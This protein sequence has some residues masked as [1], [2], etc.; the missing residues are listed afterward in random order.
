MR[1]PDKY[2]LLLIL[3][4][5]SFALRLGYI[6]E[7]RG[8]PSFLRLGRGLDSYHF[9]E[10]AE[11]ISSG[12][13]LLKEKEFYQAPLYS[14]FLAAVYSAF[15]KNLQAARVCQ[16]FLSSLGVLLVFLLAFQYSQRKTAS[17]FSAIVWAFYGPS[18]FYDG[19][20]LKTSF[21]L[22]Q[23]FL[24]MIFIYP[25]IVKDT[26]GLL[27]GFFA[28]SLITTRP[29]FAVLVPFLTGLKLLYPAKKTSGWKQLAL[30]LAG[31]LVLPG[32][33][34]IRNATLGQ[35]WFKLSSVGPR[36]VIQGQIPDDTRIGWDDSSRGDRMLHETQ[37]DLKKVISLLQEEIRKEPMIWLRLQKQKLK[38]FFSWYEYP[39]NYNFYLAKKDSFSLKM[40]FI[41]FIPV[42]IFTLCAFFISGR[43]FQHKALFACIFMIVFLCVFPFYPF[44]RFRMPLAAVLSIPS[45]IF[46]LTFFQVL[47]KK[48]ITSSFL[49][50]FITAVSFF[51]PAYLSRHFHLVRE[52]DYFNYGNYY[53]ECRLTGESE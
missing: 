17:F 33:F 16:A 32:L 4:I 36:A 46:V 28:G 14:Y 21:I 43:N 10:E 18:L 50:V 47:K 9:H 40:S 27:C 53:L 48:N 2:Q 12:D 8:H 11:K 31:A 20:I 45:G 42:L 25:F 37:G 49:F 52:I 29:N 13:T 35:P 41:S 51:Y 7:M 24:L 34:F 44:S 6:F 23:I 3:F 22:F 38:A 26:R 5:L 19:L 1:P 30:F 39:N 15:N